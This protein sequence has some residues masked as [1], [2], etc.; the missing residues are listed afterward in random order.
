VRVP[1][2]VAYAKGFEDM[3]RRVPDLTKLASI[4]GFRPETPLDRIIEDVVEDRRAAAAE[5]R[6]P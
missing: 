4:T 1:Y 3:E 2:D 5:G 6:G